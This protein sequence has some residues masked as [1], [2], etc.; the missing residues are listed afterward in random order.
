MENQGKAQAE[1]LKKIEPDQNVNGLER[2][3]ATIKNELGRKWFHSQ[4]LQPT[5]PTAWYNPTSGRYVLGPH[6]YFVPGSSYTTTSQAALTLT[7]P[8]SHRYRVYYAS[9]RNATQASTISL[10]ANIGGNAIT[11]MLTPGST[12]IL[13]TNVAVGAC[14][15]VGDLAGNPSTPITPNE[16]WLN[17]GDTLT[18]TLTTYAAANNTE[19]IFLFEDYPV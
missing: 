13:T 10:S 2:F 11:D 5:T 19:H 7:C 6:G 9:C 3:I 8:T 1:W 14:G 17:A 16:V 18:M 15:A 4:V 12:G